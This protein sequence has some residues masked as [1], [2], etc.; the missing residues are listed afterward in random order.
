MSGGREYKQFLVRMPSCHRLE[1]ESKP[2]RVWTWAPYTLEEWNYRGEPL[3]VNVELRHLYN[4]FLEDYAHDWLWYLDEKVLRYFSKVVGK[5]EPVWLVLEYEI[6]EQARSRIVNVLLDG[7]WVEPDSY[8]VFLDDDGN[9]NGLWYECDGKS[10][11]LN[12]NS[13]G[14]SWR[15]VETK[16]GIME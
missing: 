12:Q 15:W 1:L 9:Y 2:D 10:R 13:Y 7:A 8:E 5:D 16:S 4:A 3:P 11:T 14:I 6:K